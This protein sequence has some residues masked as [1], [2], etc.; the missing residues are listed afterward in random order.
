M[1]RPR[2]PAWEATTRAGNEIFVQSGNEVWVIAHLQRGSIPTEFLTPGATVKKGQ[3]LGK[4]G[5]SGDSSHPHT[6]L[7]VKKIADGFGNPTVSDACDWGEFRPMAYGD[8]Q[9][10]NHAEA[11]LWALQDDLDPSD[12]MDLDNHS[13]PHPYG[14]LYP[15]A[16]DYEFCDDC[17]DDRQYIGVWRQ[18]DH[19]ELRVKIAGWTEFTEKWDD[20]SNDSF[21]LVEINT[22]IENGERQYI[23]VFERGDGDYALWQG[24]TWNEFQNVN[25]DLEAKGFR[26][27]DMDT[28]ESGGVRFY[29][30]VWRQ[31]QDTQ[32]L[33]RTLG[34]N[35]FT[36]QW[37]ALL[38]QGLRLVDA[39]TYDAGIAGRMYVGIWREGTGV[40]GL[41]QVTGWDAFTEAWEDEAALDLRL[42]DVETFPVPGDRQFVAVFSP[43]TEG[44]ALESVTGYDTFW[45]TAEKWRFDGL[46]LV[47]VH[48][49]PLP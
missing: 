16:D 27:V 26:L 18:A 13:A 34:W 5:L 49:E 21:R 12:W 45:Q 39:E 37:D 28:F 14:L 1:P 2:V 23:G 46:R 40:Q 35:A 15:S 30:G 19:I 6:H 17:T 20:L 25:A 41:L 3:Y 22:F 7:H 38:G 8:M 31:G 32:L 9:S 10:I 42:I 48:V 43:G 47:D 29:V 11:N 4:V 44:Y 24:R 33:W 36:A